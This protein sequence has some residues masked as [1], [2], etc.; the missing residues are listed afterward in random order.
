VLAEPPLL[1]LEPRALERVGLDDLRAG[2]DHRLV[3]ALDDVGPV[4]DERL[5]AAA[6]ELVVALEVEVELLEGGA[7]AAVEDDHAVTGGSEEVTHHGKRSAT[8]TH[9]WQGL[10]DRRVSPVLAQYLD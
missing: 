6:G 9:L 8:L 4:E 10:A 1:E 5:V 3:D 2:L 7:H